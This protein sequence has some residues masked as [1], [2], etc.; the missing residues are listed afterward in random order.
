MFFDFFYFFDYERY[1]VE[2]VVFYLDRILDFCWVF[3]VVGR[4]VNMIKEIWDVI[5]D[6]KFWRIFFIF[7]VNN[8]CFYGECFYYCFMEYVL[9]GK[10]D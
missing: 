3:F 8:I 1:N 2:I 4:M 7:L 10:L 5:W 6:K 9:C